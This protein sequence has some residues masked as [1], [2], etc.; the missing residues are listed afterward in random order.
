ML[1]VDWFV[2]H[3]QLDQAMRL[4]N[5]VFITRQRE[6]SAMFGLIRGATSRGASDELRAELDLMPPIRFTL[7]D[8]DVVLRL[9]LLTPR[10]DR[11]VTGSLGDRMEMSD[12]LAAE[13]RRYVERFASARPLTRYVSLWM[14][15]RSLIQAKRVSEAAQFLGDLEAFAESTQSEMVRTA[16]LDVHAMIARQT[17]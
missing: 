11:D 15:C 5:A 13:V 8:D 14:C 3:D 2:E 1:A 7:S 9:R 6:A 16:L 17:R 12:E 4:P 10:S